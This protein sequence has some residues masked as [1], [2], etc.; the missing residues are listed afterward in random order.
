MLSTALI[1]FCL[2]ISSVFGRP[3]VNEGST[4]QPRVPVIE[5][6]A[7]MYS[8]AYETIDAIKEL[9]TVGSTDQ[10]SFA[11]D[12][13]QQTLYDYPTTEREDQANATAYSTLG[14]VVDEKIT[15]E[16]KDTDL[17]LPSMKSDQASGFFETYKTPASSV[18]VTQ[19]SSHPTE[20]TEELPVVTS[21]DNINDTQTTPLLAKQS[22]S[23]A[24]DMEKNEDTTTLTNEYRPEHL[25]PMFDAPSPIIPP[26]PS[27]L[28]SE[29]VSERALCPWTY[30]RMQITF[31]TNQ[32]IDLNVAECV[33][34]GYED[35]SITYVCDLVYETIPTLSAAGQLVLQRI[36]VACAAFRPQVHTGQPY[37]APN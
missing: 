33:I 30:N 23:G 17:L 3:P 27:G 25:I 12:S 1:I 15:E 14:V 28:V 4:G 29:S 36:A 5:P 37:L 16:I 20:T 24:A 6:E 21:A 22:V 32:S 35:A 11:A 18:H 34:D 13:S 26:C 2:T 10:P 7:A 9:L 8:K 31:A 19:L